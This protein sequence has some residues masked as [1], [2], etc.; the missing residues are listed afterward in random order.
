MN[1][2][3]AISRTG[4]VFEHEGQFKNILVGDLVRTADGKLH[5][6]AAIAD[7]SDAGARGDLLVHKLDGTPEILS[8]FSVS[9][10]YREKP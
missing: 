8:P 3:I 7:G 5:E 10:I 4:V 9:K 2:I 1:K 6:V